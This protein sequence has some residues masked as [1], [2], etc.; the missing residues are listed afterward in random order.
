MRAIF[1]P[2]FVLVRRLRC[3]IN[4][5]A[6]LSADGRGSPSHEEGRG[7]KPQETARFDRRPSL[8]P[9]QQSSR[10]YD[11]DARLLRGQSY[12]SATPLPEKVS[13]VPITLHKNCASLRGQLPFFYSK[14]KHCGLAGSRGPC[15]FIIFCFTVPICGFCSATTL[16]SPQNTF[17]AICKRAIWVCDLKGLLEFLLQ[18]SRVKL[19]VKYIY[20]A[21]ISSHLADPLKLAE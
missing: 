19:L 11:V 16:A 18:V 17:F 1:A 21:K 20:S 15:E 14:Q 8:H 5:R 3:G 7:S 6:P 10:E 12:L 4:A 2:G 13:N 9:W